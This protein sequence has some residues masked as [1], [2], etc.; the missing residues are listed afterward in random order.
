M[1]LIFESIIIVDLSNKEAKKIEFAPEKNMLTSVGNHYGKS[2]IMKSLYYSLGAEVYF[3]QTIRQL[4][5]MTILNFILNG[6]NYTVARLKNAFVLFNDNKFLGKYSSVSKFGD[7]LSEL[8]NFEIELVGKDEEGSIVKCPPAFFYLPY[9][10]DQENGWSINSYSFD[11]LTQ[12]D[13]LQRK[14]SYFF[15]LGVLDNGYVE[16]NKKQKANSKKIDKLTKEND[17]FKTVIETLKMGLDDAQM[18]FEV[19]DLERAIIN[20]K[21]EINSILNEIS[22]NRKELVETEDL[23]QRYLN[24]KEILAKYIKAKNVVPTTNTEVVECPRCGFFFEQSLSEKLEKTYLLESLNDDYTRIILEIDK[25]EKKI[26]RLKEKY[27][28]CQNRLTDYENSLDNQQDLYDTYLR[29]KTTRKLLDDYRKNIQEN[30][31]LISMLSDNNKIIKESL[32]RYRKGRESANSVYLKN[33]NKQF[34]ILDIP[35]EQVPKESEP[36]SSIQASGAYGPRCK[37]AQVLSFL[38][39]QKVISNT[40]ITFPLV[41]DS[42][43][44]LEQDKKH[45]ESVLKTLLAWD[46]TENQIIVASIEG[47]QIAEKIP[48][49]KIIKLN[50]K[51]NHIMTRHEYEELENLI[52]NIIISF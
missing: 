36:G 34:G 22:K 30:V 37:V 8:Y 29:A 1:K 33:L 35:M 15:H 12:F 3:P 39:T 43:N 13:L 24:E 23:Y 41:I 17:K 45:L 52:D 46:E 28:E 51:V 7:V 26:K 14:D 38:E 42:P 47:E 27:E 18:A 25:S 9:Y 4:N 11:K 49:V 48:G 21:N 40:T 44:V 6:V 20:R 16:K 5:Y 10:I 31:E 32:K 50:N 2:V 19:K